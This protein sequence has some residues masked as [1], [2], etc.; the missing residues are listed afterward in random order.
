[1][2]RFYIPEVSGGTCILSE[3]ESKHCVRVLRLL[4]N[5]A[6]EITDGKGNRF[7]AVIENANPKACL[8]KINRTSKRSSYLHGN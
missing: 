6:V 2:H 7:K 4:E 5:D 8:L 3:E 1:M